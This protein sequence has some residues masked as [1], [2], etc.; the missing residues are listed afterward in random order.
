[1]IPILML[2]NQLATLRAV[3]YL[4]GVHLDAKHEIV[5]DLDKQIHETTVDIKSHSYHPEDNDPA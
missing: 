2:K 3:R 4:M 1:M 5:R